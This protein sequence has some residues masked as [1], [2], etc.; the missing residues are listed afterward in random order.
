MARWLA[1]AAS[2]LL[3]LSVLYSRLSGND[4]APF[5]VL[6]VLALTAVLVL[7]LL[8]RAL[9]QQGAHAWRS[10]GVAALPLVYAAVAIVLARH[11]WVDL[12]SLLGFR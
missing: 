11:G 6:T 8:V 3:V 2:V 5:L 9:L 1:A 12:M 4:K 7:A 10:V